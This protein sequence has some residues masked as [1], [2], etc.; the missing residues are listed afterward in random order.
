MPVPVVAAL[1]LAPGHGQ[2]SDPD[3]L[4]G[5]LPAGCERVVGEF[6]ELCGHGPAAQFGMGYRRGAVPNPPGQLD[7]AEPGRVPQ[8]G[9][10]PARLCACGSDGLPQVSQRVLPRRRGV[11]LCRCV[12]AC[13]APAVM[14][15]AGA[16]A[17][18]E[19][20]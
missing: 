19:R 17:G 2:I 9:E 13:P 6:P 18:P 4:G 10:Q 8:A 3:A 5:Q 14:L 11:V 15:C 7:L 1:F 20:G 12:P 16:A